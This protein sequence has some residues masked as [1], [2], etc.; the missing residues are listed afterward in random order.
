MGTSKS[1]SFCEGL[2]TRIV[3]V[4]LQSAGY[5]AGQF[6]RMLIEQQRHL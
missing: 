1:P 4:L 6:T 3:K 2:P 5:L